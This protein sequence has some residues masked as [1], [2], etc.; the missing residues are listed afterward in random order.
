MP[1]DSTTNNLGQESVKPPGKSFLS[2]FGPGLI[3]GASDDDPSGIGTYAMAGASLGYSPLWTALVTFPLM[4]GIQFICAK[5]ALVYGCGLAGIM[6]RHYPRAITYPAIAALVIANT[7]NAA[8]DLQAIA[9][10]INLLV[11]VQ[12]ELLIVPI[13]ILILIVQV[14]GSYRVIEKIFRWLALSLLAYIG[15]A[16][17]AHPDWHAVAHGTIVPT[18]RFDA[19]YLSMLVAL[20]GTTISPYLF[21]WQGSHEI[22]EEIA[23]GKTEI[24]QRKG[25][26]KSEL[27]FA[28]WDVIAGMLLSNVVMYFIILA[29][30]ATLNAAGKTEIGTATDAAQALRPI[31]GN[32][33]YVLMALGLI[34]TGVLAV[35]ILTGSAAY[36]VAELF[37]W[38]C[39]LDAKPN[40]AKGFY[41]V[42]SVCTLAALAINFF[43]I[44]PMQSLF[45]TA[46]INGL[47]S[48]PL[49]IVIMLIANNR[50]VMG[51]RINGLF[52]NGLGWVT[53]VAMFAAA[54][55]LVWSWFH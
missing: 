29:S 41:I 55:V 50:E 26:S 49:L 10:G 45:W 12:I 40:E 24:Q 15:A 8:A 31:A 27:K 44:N 53:T 16:F 20:L 23:Q 11:P 19:N 14:W 47:L 25:A 46:V 21:F 22:E 51:K 1:S 38:E 37:G 9:A 42:M 34:G 28:A 7:I 54:I 36:S 3:T 6:R 43:G 52:L 48:P 13:G 18:I 2:K 17:L 30:A 35:P 32:A 39:S 33:A 5:I 4:A